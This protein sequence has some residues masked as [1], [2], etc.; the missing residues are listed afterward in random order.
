ME[1]KTKM[2]PHRLILLSSVII[3]GVL[4]S[5]SGYQMFQQLSQ[6]ETLVSMAKHEVVQIGNQT[7][8]GFRI[9]NK[10]G[11]GLNYSYLLSLNLTST[12]VYNYSDT[13]LIPNGGSFEFVLY[14]TPT[15]KGIIVVTIKIYKGNEMVLI[16]DLTYYIT[17]Q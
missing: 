11:E 6:P 13:I 10:E 7:I 5:F 3:L 4:V 15:E 2:I 16:E 1:S 9:T 12:E 17:V 8:I 14:T